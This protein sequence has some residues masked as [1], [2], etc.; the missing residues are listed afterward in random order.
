ASFNELYEKVK[1]NVLSDFAHQQYPFD[2]LVEELGLQYDASRTPL[3][4]I[5]LTLHNI[6]DMSDYKMSNITDASGI[7]DLGE[8]LCK[9]D[10]EFHVQPI[11]G[12]LSIGVMYNT[13]LY[14]QDM[15]SNLL[16]HFKE[17]TKNLI[18]NPTKAIG[19]T[20][21]L[22]Q[23]EKHELLHD[24][25]GDTKQ[26]SGKGFL[27]LFKEQVAKTPE[28]TALVYKDKTLSYE[29]LDTIST[30]LAHSLTTDHKVQLGDY[31]GI[32]LARD[33]RFVW[34]ILGIL[35]SGAAYV[36]I[37][38]AYPEDRKAYMVHDAGIE[39]LITDTTYMFDMDYYEGAL[40]ALDVEF[41]KD[42]YPTTPLQLEIP[43]DS[44]AYVIYTSGS[45]GLPKGVLVNHE[46]L[47]NLIHWQ[48]EYLGRVEQSH[49]LQYFSYNFDGAVGET[50]W[51]LSF[52][53]KLCMYDLK[54]HE[55]LSISEYILKNKIQV[56][57][58]I[59]SLLKTLSP[60]D[61]TGIDNVL[62]VVV[63][64]VFDKE[65]YE[66]WKGVGTLVNGYG[67]T[68]NTV[69][70]TVYELGD[71]LDHNRVPIGKAITNTGVYIL[72]D[73]GEL[74]GKGITGEL[75]VNGANVAQGYLNREEL[76]RD[77]FVAD[78]YEIPYKGHLTH[79]TEAVAAFIEK[80]VEVSGNRSFFQDSIETFYND[81]ELSQDLREK[82]KQ[83]YQSESDI[84]R[85]GFLRYLNESKKGSY[86]SFGFTKEVVKELLAGEKLQ[87][88]SVLDIGFGNG[89]LLDILSDMGANVFGIDANP[90]FVH[91]Q[92]HKDYG[93]VMSRV[94]LSPEDFKISTG[95]TKDQFD[96]TFM[97]LVLDR[98]E[99]PK[100]VLESMFDTLKSDG[101]FCVQ[102][103][104]PIIP[105][106]DGDH[107]DRIVYT[108][109]DHYITKGQSVA[110]DKYQLL[111]LLQQ[112]GGGDLA[113]RSMD[114]YVK[115]TDGNQ[116]YTLW[117]FTGVNNGKG[118]FMYKTGDVGKWLADGNIDFLGRKDSQVKIRGHRIELEEI[119]KV[120]EEKE[121]IQ[122]AIVLIKESPSKEKQLVAYYTSS[123][124][125][126]S[127]RV[128][129]YLL[130]KLPKYMLPD[131]YVKLKEVPLTRTGK[132]DY[133]S[134]PE[135]DGMEL[136]NEL[137]YVAPR[138]EMETQLVAI[139]SKIMNREK[140]GIRDDF[141][142]LG[143]NSLIMIQIINECL[144]TLNIKITIKDLFTNT[145]IETLAKYIQFIQQQKDVNLSKLNEIEI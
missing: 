26:Y 1:H 42:A 100:R 106:D 104:L 46:N 95:F 110:Q 118:K 105:F 89:E 84:F 14:D 24:F 25:K 44:T 52:G 124:D 69:Y 77:R 121:T 87:G 127:N 13:D 32:Q 55:E 109:E 20:D 35:K 70:S 37:D 120:L 74:V 144:K 47:S 54:G 116:K 27:T 125:E 132:I 66:R 142:M 17:L 102:A 5:S 101:K 123:T 29:E 3:Y 71:R 39:L 122:N 117:S 113:V 61:F 134:L 88:K 34:S 130:D 31:V 51:T 12:M 141:F 107:E 22:K 108:E 56:F 28:A 23:E 64:E 6:S 128:Q 36:S 111:T 98:L 19:Y 43:M 136:I 58:T 15:I 10:V 75:Y 129:E 137:N 94:D 143:G 62:I 91:N 16:V 40:L 21:Y 99:Y 73:Q 45:T 33:E 112:L 97:T 49:V 4:D 57:V 131:T 65:L 79:N 82:I 126:N 86:S 18:D 92:S 41:E 11:G 138:N 59:P 96:I 93:V 115:S 2:T 145:T 83:L 63:G 50:F 72:D 114:Y 139:W 103:L 7:T 119:E 48:G 53:H 80:E 133:K 140:I 30:Q 60:E 78:I 38:P 8:G 135:P 9:N 81:Q 68:E 67:P 76:T 85:T 90:Y